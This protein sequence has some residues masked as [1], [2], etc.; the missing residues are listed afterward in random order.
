MSN[1]TQSQVV[2]DAHSLTVGSGNATPL[3]ARQFVGLLGRL[4]VKADKQKSLPAGN[5]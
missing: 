1:E 5:K 3:G 4:I 2:C